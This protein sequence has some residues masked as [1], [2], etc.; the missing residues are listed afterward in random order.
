MNPPP[1]STCSE[2]RAQLSR[3]KTEIQQAL[4]SANRA[5]NALTGDT[6]TNGL[7]YV[8]SVQD[9]LKRVLET[10]PKET[11]EAEATPSCPKCEH[12][13]MV[14]WVREYSLKNL[15]ANLATGHCRHCRFRFRAE[16]SHFPEDGDYC[17]AVDPDQLKSCP[18]WVHRSDPSYPVLGE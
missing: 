11:S 8:N 10:Y 1:C 5:G 7:Y 15:G 18:A 4:V 14:G 2:L 6:D 9:R 12:L 13:A 3:L 17:C 16:D